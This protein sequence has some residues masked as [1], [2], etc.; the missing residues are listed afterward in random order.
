[1]LLRR[2]IDHVS[3]Q[4]WT[5]VGIDF[6]IV[7][8]G[9]FIGIQV[10]NWNGTLADRREEARFLR[11]LHRDF[12]QLE[13]LIGRPSDHRLRIAEDLTAAVDVLFGVSPMRP[14]SDDECYALATS[15]IV[16]VGRSEMPSIVRLRNAGRTGI[17]RDEPLANAI[18]ELEQQ[19]SA[20]DRIDAEVSQ[21]G[22]EVRSNPEL[23]S[24]RSIVGPLENNAVGLEREQR[25]SC[26]VGRLL[27]DQRFL[28]QIANNA[29]AYD[30]FLRDGL[31]PWINA[32]DGVHTRLD[33]ILG[34]EHTRDQP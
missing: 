22:F 27:A 32:L 25:Y 7:V 15:N 10:S 19:I 11:A 5:A 13:P 18:A 29:D 28:N 24:G 6:V 4:N 26:S 12:E 2:V 14:L 16:Y 33:Q 31:L 9:V 17:I 34:I 8:V 21:H 23:F 30:A 20:L 3:A 1:M